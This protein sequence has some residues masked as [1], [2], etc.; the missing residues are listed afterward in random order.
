MQVVEFSLEDQ[1]SR[2]NLLWF[3]E[4]TWTG[5]TIQVWYEFCPAGNSTKQAGYSH[6]TT[7]CDCGAQE[8]LGALQSR[9]P[10][11]DAP[12][13]LDA[14]Q[15][16]WSHLDRALGYPGH[17]GILRWVGLDKQQRRDFTDDRL[18]KPAQREF[19]FG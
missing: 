7:C 3:P 15:R 13:S 10:G 14:L 8:L 2:D 19:N 17:E 4:G 6:Y 18:G 9:Y 1:R 12:M 16:L 5:K 11:K